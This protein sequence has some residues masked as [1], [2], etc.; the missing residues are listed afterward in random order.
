[1]YAGHSEEESEEGGNI[2]EE[3]TD[4]MVIGA[5]VN[6]LFLYSMDEPGPYFVAGIG[7]G[8]V[9]MEWEEKSATDNSLGT[10]LPGGGS[11]QS[12]DGS[13]GGT[14]INFGIGHRFN[15][16]LDFRAQLPT[17]FV[18]SA[19]GDA[20]SVVPTFTITVGYRF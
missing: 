1:M 4:V 20:T 13:S 18:F 19:P 5:L 8:A 17:F 2:Y 3:A 12:V 15:K 9:S 10:L 14:I 16:Q 6:Y 7:F 11:M